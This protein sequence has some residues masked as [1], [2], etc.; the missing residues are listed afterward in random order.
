MTPIAL[1]YF[2]LGLS[3]LYWPFVTLF[4]K[5]RVLGAQWLIMSALTSMGLV[6]ILYS[7]F[8]NSFLKGEYILVIMFMVLS[9]FTPPLIQAAVSNLT[10]TGE[11]RPPLSRLNV[12]VI[13]AVVVVILLAASVIIGG[14]DMYRLWIQR[15]SEGIAHHFYANS[16]RYNLIVLVHFYLYWFLIVAE[17]TFVG[18]YSIIRIN[19]FS[20]LIDEYYTVNR[21]NRADLLG[22]YLF[23]ALNCF[24][25]VFSY[26]MYPFNFPRP[27]YGTAFGCILQAV[28]MFLIGYFAFR[29]PVGVEVLNENKKRL[30]MQSRKSLHYL[31][32]QLAEYIE[33]EKEYLNPDVSVFLLADHFRV[34]QDD[35]I[36]AVHQRNGSSFSDYIDSLRIE[37]A[38][39]LMND[40]EDLYHTDDPEDI[41]RLAHQCGYL[42]REKFETSFQKVMQTT[43]KDYFQ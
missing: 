14:S 32:Q 8:F 4:F 19:R 5:R 37:R 31:G 3:A 34:S 36:D 28:D 42:D 9:M 16:W 2:L 22:T 35:I 11:N 15:G 29:T 21:V 33:K 10:D 26:I 38:I 27:V 13:P 30:P 18:I 25:V 20:R 24:F 7:T 12:L 17:T 40:S 39:K 1:I 43:L 23:V 41:T 6:V